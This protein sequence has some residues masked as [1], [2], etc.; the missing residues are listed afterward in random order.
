MLLF[1]QSCLGTEDEQDDLDCSW[2]RQDAQGWVCPSLCP[3]APCGDLGTSPSAP[4]HLTWPCSVPT[5]LSLW[6]QLKHDSTLPL[7][8]M[9]FWG[10]PHGPTSGQW[11]VAA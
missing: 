10:S 11:C 3:T 9:V 6:E 2:A 4:W 7:S 5:L 1:S 8:M